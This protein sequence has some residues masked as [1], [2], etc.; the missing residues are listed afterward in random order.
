ME[1]FI[2]RKGH[3]YEAK[4]VRTIRNWR[5]ACDERGLTQLQQSRFNYQLLEMIL[6]E[7]MPWHNTQYDFSLLEVNR[8]DTANMRIICACT[9]VRMYIPVTY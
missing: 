6:D 8:Y 9:H 1:E 4:Y 3:T 7:L 2:E 5:R